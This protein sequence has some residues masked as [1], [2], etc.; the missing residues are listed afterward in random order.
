[1]EKSHGLGNVHI[2]VPWLLTGRCIACVCIQTCAAGR[3]NGVVSFHGHLQSTQAPPALLIWLDGM[4]P[5]IFHCILILIFRLE[6]L[7][8]L[9]ALCFT[10]RPLAYG[11]DEIGEKRAPWPIRPWAAGL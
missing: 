7:V 9:T 10:T 6:F 4:Q 11:Q 8:A 2:L 5:F 3:Y 1:M